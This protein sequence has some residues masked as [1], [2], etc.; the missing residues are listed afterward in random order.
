VTSKLNLANKPFTNRALPWI[1]TALILSISLLAFVLIVRSAGKANAE[2]AIL[3]KEIR[4]LKVEEEGLQK[5]TQEVKA[6]LSPEQLLTLNAAHQLIDRK[7]FS[8]SRL[9]ID[10][11]SALPGAVRVTR[12]GVR[13]VAA[14]G[15]RTVA[16][17][18]LAVVA[19]S[20]ATVTEMISN[21]DR[22]GIFQ[23]ELRS[24]NLQKGRG[25]SGTE[26]EL[27]VIY[28]PRLGSPAT[29]NQTSIA[30]VG[31]ETVTAGANR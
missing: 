1:L 29:V 11:E 9:F 28:R 8:W 2:A 7:Q 18:E 14:A 31:R 12:I 19:K 25:E 5:K 22:N 16:E 6:S 23:A 15:D 20:Y 26:Y 3:Q 17:L 27:F 13:D 10:L 24:Q 4:T 30:S 21:M